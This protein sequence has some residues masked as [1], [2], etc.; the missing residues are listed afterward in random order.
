MQTEVLIVG[1]GPCGL[2]LALWLTLQGIEVRIVDRAPASG[3]ASRAFA[4]QARTLELYDRI[5]LAR[6]AIARGR[7]I[8]A[9][10]VRL[11][12]QSAQ[13]IPFGN[14]GRG[15]SPFPYVLILLQ[16]D[17]EKLLIDRL[18][19]AGVHVERSTEVVDLEPTGQGVRA[20]LTGPH[21]GDRECEAAYVCGCDGAGSTVRELMGIG[22]PGGSSEEMFFVADVAAKGPLTDGE[23]HYLMAGDELCSVFPLRGEG[24]LRLIGLVPKA[25]RASQLDF[26]FEDVAARILS[27]AGLEVTMVESF[28]TYRVHQRIAAQWRKG[29][30]FLLGDAS[31][32]HSPA[33]GQGLNAGVADAANLAW[34]LAAVLRGAA[35]EALLDSYQSEGVEAA[36]QIAATTD[37]GFALQASRGG[38]MGLARQAIARLAPGLM[39]LKPV[40]HAAFLAISQ[41]GINYRAAGTCVGQAGRVAGGDRLPWVRLAGHASNF[42]P[43]RGVGWQ[44]QVYGAVEPALS[45]ACAAWGLSLHAFAWT[46]EMG[47]AGLARDAVYL[48]RPDGYVAYAAAG[49]DPAGLER[50]RA[51]LG[52]RFSPAGPNPR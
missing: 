17:H 5:G 29:R 48:V 15:L 23:L 32:V 38:V 41:L 50:Y 49:Q 35:G 25:V 31:H 16:D 1:A 26:R 27:D 7:P 4:L 20:R 18:A 46:P 10:N 2:A 3:L 9:M 34:K 12:G 24:R 6:E 47:R 52:L 33:G 13:R 30:V 42:D 19:A 37:L 44:A 22:F 11:D 39:G 40:R 28:A 36:R 43:L 45:A 14:L 8:A 51:G 21:G